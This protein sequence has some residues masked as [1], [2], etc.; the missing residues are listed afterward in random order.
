MASFSGRK[1]GTDEKIVMRKN[2]SIVRAR[3]IK[4][5][6][7]TLILKDYDVLRGSPHDPI[8]TLTFGNTW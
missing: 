4:D 1:A 5:I 6:Q 7:K 2:G 8:R 3:A